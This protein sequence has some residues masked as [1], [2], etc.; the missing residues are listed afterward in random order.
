[1]LVELLG[2]PAATCTTQLDIW[3]EGA[4][5]HEQL[6]RFPAI[7]VP[8][9]DMTSYNTCPANGCFFTFGR[10]PVTIDI[11]TDLKGG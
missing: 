8:T 4:V 7:Q 9:F 6:V 11:I 10:P 1:V 2:Y 5:A 3:V